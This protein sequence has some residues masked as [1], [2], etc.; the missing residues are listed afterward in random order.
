[1]TGWLIG[2]ADLK[3]AEQDKAIPSRPRGAL[4]LVGAW[5]DVADDEI[6]ALITHI[7]ASREEDMGRRVDLSTGDSEE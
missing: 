6:E 3:R 7:Y 5:S 2:V 4:A 1:M